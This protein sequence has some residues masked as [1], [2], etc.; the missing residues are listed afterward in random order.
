MQVAQPE[1]LCLIDDN[2][3]GI[4]DV[5][6]TL[7]NSCGKQYIIVIVDEIK[8]DFFQFGRFHLPMPD[9]DTAI[10]DI[11]LYHRF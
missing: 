5:N 4:R 7:Y 9:A 2:G 3:I 8:D 10:G 1:V 11:T 6:A